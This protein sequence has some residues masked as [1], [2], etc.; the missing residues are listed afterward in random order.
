MSD[1]DHQYPNQYVNLPPE[2]WPDMEFSWDLEHKSQRLVL[3]GE[4][5]ADFE[6]DYPNGFALGWTSLKCL[7]R[8]MHKQNRRSLKTIWKYG[9][10]DKL[11]K[12]IDHISR[13]QPITPPL[14]RVHKDLPGK[15]H[16]GGGNHRY[17]VA[18][19]SEQD[20]IP[21][22]ALPEEKEEIDKIL[23]VDWC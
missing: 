21:V 16:L 6:K 14:I 8:K 4:S 13:D 23:K 15:I 10:K 22:Y 11:A 12:A 19:F 18:V 20:R 1:E 9:D 5:Q 2:Q 7:D 3:D 17:T